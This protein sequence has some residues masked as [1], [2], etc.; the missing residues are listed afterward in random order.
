[1]PL[2]ERHEFG[3]VI[4]LSLDFEISSLSGSHPSSSQRKVASCDSG[5]A[6]LVLKSFD[7]LPPDP[8]MVAI[9]DE[10]GSSYAPREI[11]STVIEHLTAILGE[12]SAPFSVGGLT[13]PRGYL[14]KDVLLHGVIPRLKLKSVSTAEID[15]GWHDRAHVQ[16]CRSPDEVP[17][18]PPRAESPIKFLLF[19]ATDF[20]AIPQWMT[21]QVEP[22]V[23]TFP[24]GPLSLIEAH[25]LVE[26]QLGR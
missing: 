12:P 22:D 7:R 21:S 16:Y 3:A 2:R 17:D 15:G 8:V 6:P 26:A 4:I 23:R 24:V 18:A 13:A 1:M 20:T 19:T 25:D 10:Y 14:I 9:L 11:E 5:V